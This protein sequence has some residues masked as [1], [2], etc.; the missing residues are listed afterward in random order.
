MD[1]TVPPGAAMLLDFI[2]SIE[3]GRA[4]RASYDV[5]F[6]NRQTALERPITQMNLGDLID[7]QKQW[8]TKAWAKK[9]KATKASS[10]AGGY[11]FMRA[12]L[13]DLSKELNLIGTQVFEPDFQ[14]RLGFHLLK[15]R[16]YEQYMAG[17]ISRT[18]FGKRLAQEWASLP[19]LAPTQGGSRPVSRGQSFYAGDGLNKSLVQPERVEALLNKIKTVTAKPVQPSPPPVPVQEARKVET[20]PVAVPV[21]KRGFWEI[22]LDYLLN[23]K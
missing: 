13:I 12:T 8:S 4:D 14:D 5:I 9:F 19:V 3:I 23:R 18:E 10:A 15:R 7:A 16:G 20:A 22:V 11:Q 2:R 1:K 17:K 6:G 21:A